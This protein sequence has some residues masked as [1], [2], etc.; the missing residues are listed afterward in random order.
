MVKFVKWTMTTADWKR[1][2]FHQAA[3]GSDGT[4]W[5]RMGRTA[6]SQESKP[7]AAQNGSPF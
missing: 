1:L 4:G 3:F 2:E 6:K 7:A 5:H